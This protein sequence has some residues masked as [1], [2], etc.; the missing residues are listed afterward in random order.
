VAPLPTLAASLA[1]L[2]FIIASLLNTELDTANRIMLKMP[3]ASTITKNLVIIL[4]SIHPFGI[5]F[6]H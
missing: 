5:I 4:K 1:L 6:Q 3:I 2:S